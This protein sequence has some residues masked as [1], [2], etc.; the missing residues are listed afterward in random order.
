[1]SLAHSVETSKIIT[2][3]IERG[4][5]FKEIASVLHVKYND[6]YKYKQR[7][8]AGIGDLRGKSGK[9]QYGSD[10]D[11]E[12]A[13]VDSFNERF[14]G[15]YEYIGGFVNVDGQF[16]CKCLKCETVFEKNAQYVRKNRPIKCPYCTEVEKREKEI[17]ESRLKEE[18]AKRKKEEREQKEAAQRLE[19][20]KM[21][22]KVCPVCG[23]RFKAKAK[24]K[25]PVKIYCSK[26]CLQKQHVRNKEIKRRG[27]AESNGD[28]DNT[29][30]IELLYKRDKGVCHI[31]GGECDFSD[32]T[33]KVSKGVNAFVVGENYP[34]IDHVVPLSK[35][36]THQWDN[37][38]LAHHYCN[39]RKGNKEFRVMKN[40]QVTL[41]A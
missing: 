4:M 38:R 12:T 13:F 31:C 17:D 11:R 7:Y 40:G 8:L 21:I 23:E 36:G 41:Y 14:S 35:G 10:E 25:G 22:D 5:P 33:H 39:T 9:N 2:E 28:V 29:I 34:S 24:A 18:I 15:T 20:E 26:D 16:R 32:Y 19:R 3:M 1:M 27:N 30:T 37:V 6:I